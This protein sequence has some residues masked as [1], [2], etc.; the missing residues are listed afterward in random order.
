MPITRKLRPR[1]QAPQALSRAEVFRLI[2]RALGESD[3]STALLIRVIW[4][5]VARV[6]EALSLKPADIELR[7]GA[8]ESTEP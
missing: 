8:F 7:G 2:G 3:R 1:K 4:E 6:S 5:G